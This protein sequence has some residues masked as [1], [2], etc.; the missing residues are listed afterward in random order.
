MVAATPTRQHNSARAALA[1]HLAPQMLFTF[2]ACL[3]GQSAVISSD[4]SLECLVIVCLSSNA[5]NF[6][7]IQ[8]QEGMTGLVVRPGA[9]PGA[10]ICRWWC[11]SAE[12]DG[13]FT[14]HITDPTKYLF[15]TP[16][17]TTGSFDDIRSLATRQPS[18][19]P[20]HNDPQYG[21]ACRH[22]FSNPMNR[23]ASQRIRAACRLDRPRKFAREIRFANFGHSPRPGC[24]V[25]E[26]RRGLTSRLVAILPHLSQANSNQ[27]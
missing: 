16:P 11:D 1:G 13:A 19:S 12:N 3:R 5:Q 24:T 21:L 15:A 23:A 7:H 2:A 27:I 25:L 22:G 8:A 4:Q 14:G 9:I 10:R 20:P 6:D 17:K 18:R 26:K